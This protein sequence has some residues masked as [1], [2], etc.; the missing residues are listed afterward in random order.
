MKKNIRFRHQKE[1]D[2]QTLVTAIEGLSDAPSENENL[3][4]TREV[5][6]L[7]E[8]A[9]TDTESSDS[10][11]TKMTQEYKPRP[12]T[13]DDE[14]YDDIIEQFATAPTKPKYWFEEFGD[15][16]SCSCGTLN[17]EGDT[18]SNC[19]LEKELLRSLFILHKPADKQKNN[20]LQIRPIKGDHNG[21]FRQLSAPGKKKLIIAVCVCAVL[22]LA[23]TIPLL[24]HLTG[25]ASQ[26]AE[27]NDFFSNGQYEKAISKYEALG[28]YKDSQNLICEC[29]I[30]MGDE[31]FTAANY[32]NAISYY[33]KALDLKEN[34]G[35]K[36]KIRNCYIAIGDT[37]YKDSKYEDAIAS[38]SVAA[39]IKNDDAVKNKI[40]D[41]KFSY[42]KA[43]KDERTS[44]VE[45][46]MSE[47]MAL[48]Y[49]GIKEI[50]NEY[51]AW[52]VN[53]IANTSETDFSTDKDSFSRNDIV[54]F[55]TT[56]SGGEP[57]ETITLYY[58]VIWPNG[59]N[60]IASLESTWKDGSTITARFQ[61]PIPLFGKEGI[62]TFELYDKSTNE[63]MGRDTITF[64]N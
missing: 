14:I 31:L 43:H 40:N 53:I 11:D 63:L 1:F 35:T 52:H 5:E 9:P 16:W 2:T 54:Y 17:E 33:Q 51:Y 61:Y 36:E 48:K 44:Q 28:D 49:S 37:E 64:K 27:A 24:I 56:L 10:S 6:D 41:A 58:K 7:K 8:L 30:A 46:Y 25:P 18:C 62:L 47:L 12:L 42:I 19:G 38:Y 13:P 50:Y 59:A 57:S 15:S 60:E 29:Y 20:F 34:D 4:H 22:I 32:K 26:Y 55:H 3:N 21:S 45:Q 39:D 23:C